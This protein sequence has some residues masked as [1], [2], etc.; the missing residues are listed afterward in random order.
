MRR[1][2]VLC[3][4][5]LIGLSVQAQLDTALYELQLDS[6][7]MHLEAEFEDPAESPLDPNDLDSFDGLPYF[8]FN[9][10][11][12]VE[13][14]FIRTPWELPFKM[15]TSTDREPEYV[16]YGELHFV[17]QGDSCRLNLYRNLGL[18]QK[19]GYKNY[20]FL[21]FTDATNS[22][23]T[24]GGGRYLDFRLDIGKDSEKVII[25]FNRAYNP[26]CAYS[27][28]WSCPIP[29]K[30]NHLEMRVEA[31]VKAWKKH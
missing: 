7:R 29:P 12:I 22:D 2:L 13:A 20:F 11:F 17:L 9:P 14:S 27:S 31:G 24:Y 21:P 23:S 3:F 19:A 10:N 18:A 26:Y 15:K 1:A 30:E 4:L 8:A 16:K 28:R 5:I 6:I 25:D